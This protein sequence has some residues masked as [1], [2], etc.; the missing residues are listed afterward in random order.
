MRFSPD[1]KSG[2]K[3][4]TYFFVVTKTTLLAQKI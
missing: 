1:E 2:E 3:R 4:I